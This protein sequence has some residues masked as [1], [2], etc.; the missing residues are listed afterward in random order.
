M[1]NCIPISIGPPPSVEPDDTRTL[2]E[3]DHRRGSIGIHAATDPAH[4][5]RVSTSLWL[6][7]EMAEVL[8]NELLRAVEAWRNHE[9]VI[10]WTAV[11]RPGGGNGG[12]V[13]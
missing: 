5:T 10:A 8:A 6:P 13:Q 1:K 11:K 7:P 3:V 4:P 9:T 2:V 12:G